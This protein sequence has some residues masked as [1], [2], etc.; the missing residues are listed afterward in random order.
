MSVTFRLYAAI[1]K[2]VA[3]APMTVPDIA[4]KVG[5]QARIGQR[6]TVRMHSLGLIYI[7]AW[8]PS[9]KGPASACW[10]FGDKEDEPRPV[11]RNGKVIP[12]RK[13]QPFRPRVTGVELMHF[14]QL[15]RAL[16]E[17]VS[18]REIQEATGRSSS[19]IYRTLGALRSMG[20]I[21]ICEW[22]R[23]RR[24]GDFTPLWRMAINKPD[25]AR[26]RV[27]TAQELHARYNVGRQQRKNTLTVLRA[28]A[29]N[30]SVFDVAAAA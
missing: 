17:P 20:L 27:Y 12:P 21:H 8:S 2:A 7:A 15:I 10:M 13:R 14:A 25:K 18:V 16:A 1:I 23:R 19:T 30:N 22:D 4:A 9:D 26:P 28:L 11:C 5:C 29:S 3:L 6:L 24:A